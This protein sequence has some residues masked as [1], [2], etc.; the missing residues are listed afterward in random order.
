M[1]IGYPTNPTNQAYL[2]GQPSPYNNIQP[3]IIQPNAL[4]VYQGEQRP[5][6]GQ[7]VIGVTAS[8]RNLEG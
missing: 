4:P 3:Q 1:P 5:P 7:P 2:I 6:I 8:F